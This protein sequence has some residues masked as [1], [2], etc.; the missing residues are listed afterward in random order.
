MQSGVLVLMQNHFLSFPYVPYPLGIYYSV[1]ATKF[2][3]KLLIIAKIIHRFISSIAIG[4]VYISQ[5][6]FYV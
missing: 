5:F 1:E 3:Q 4:Y 2:A 6:Q